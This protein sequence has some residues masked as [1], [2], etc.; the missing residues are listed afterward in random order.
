VGGKLKN[1]PKE[2]NRAA[3]IKNEKRCQINARNS[4]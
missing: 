2:Q 1:G 3:G 4:K